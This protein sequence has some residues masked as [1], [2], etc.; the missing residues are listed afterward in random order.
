MANFATVFAITGY[1]NR[2]RRKTAL[3]KRKSRENGRT[4]LIG[5]THRRSHTAPSSGANVTVVIVNNTAGK[6]DITDREQE[7]QI[8]GRQTPSAAAG[9][10]RPNGRELKT[11]FHDV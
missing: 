4:L 1:V 8:M 9:G 2:S 7:K 3:K 6:N 11:S 10:I 5:C